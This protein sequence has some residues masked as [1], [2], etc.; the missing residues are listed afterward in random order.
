MDINKEILQPIDEALRLTPEVDSSMCIEG[1]VWAELDESVQQGWRTQEEAEDT[2]L[3]W[4]TDYLQ[5]KL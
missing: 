4:R 2:F 3:Q 1:Q 5:G